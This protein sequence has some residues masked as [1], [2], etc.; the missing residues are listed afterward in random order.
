M[1]GQ[2]RDD[3][4]HRLRREQRGLQEVEEDIGSHREAQNCQE[5]DPA[6]AHVGVAAV[7]GSF[8]ACTRCRH[9][10]DHASHDGACKLQQRPDGGDADRACADEADVVGPHIHCA[11]ADIRRTCSLQGCEDGYGSSPC[12]Q[13]AQQHRHADGNADEV[14]GSHQR[15]RERHVVAADGIRTHAEEACNLAGHNLRSGEGSERR[16]RDRA[17]HHGEKAFA[18]FVFGAVRDGFARTR[19]HF[20]H[21]GGGDTFG[22]GK[23]RC[24]HHRAAQRN[25]EQHAENPARRAD[26]ECRPKRKAHPRAHDDEARQHEDDGRKRAGRGRHRL[27]D[28]VLEDRGAFERR[29][30]RHRDHRGGDRCGE[31]QPHLQSEIDVGGREDRGDEYAEDDAPNRQLHNPSLL[32]LRHACPRGLANPAGTLNDRAADAKKEGG[33]APHRPSH[34]WYT[35]VAGRL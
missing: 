15:E 32:P 7:G 13:K 26:Q 27:H 28:I 30:Y 14:A 31:G 1:N 35:L 9:R 2:R 12:D 11:R 20:K 25:G 19:A 18:R 23:V 8:R 21:F 33:S 10:S 6:E 16:R 3:E 34:S 4:R 24:R 17:V 29:E 22:I 5:R